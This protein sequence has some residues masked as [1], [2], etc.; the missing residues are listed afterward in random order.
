MAWWLGVRV[1]T[2][3]LQG[4]GIVLVAVAL[5]PWFGE[6][7]RAGRSW[8]YVLLVSWRGIV[9]W[10]TPGVVLAAAART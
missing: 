2:L 5:V 7:I 9:A 8:S 10:A 6:D 1:R 4:L 3:P